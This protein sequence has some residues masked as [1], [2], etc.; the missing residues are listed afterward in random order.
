M[1]ISQ[2]LSGERFLEGMIRL[3]EPLSGEVR[4]QPQVERSERW[5]ASQKGIDAS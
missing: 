5:V 1:F 3:V 4:N 2:L